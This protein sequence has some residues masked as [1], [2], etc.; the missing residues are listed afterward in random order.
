MTKEKRIA[1]VNLQTFFFARELARRLEGTGVTVNSLHP[2]VVDTELMRHMGL[3][4]SWVSGPFVRLLTWPFLKTAKSGAQTTLYA[5]LDPDLDKVTG[6][7][8][9][10]CQV[11][12]TS[13]LAKNDEL[14]KWLWAVSEKGTKTETVV[15]YIQ[16]LSLRGSLEYSF[17]SV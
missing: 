9:S 12:E 15:R 7:Y 3:F 6:L 4:T 14:A 13:D 8:F 11:R 16:L 1:K 17:P 2:G 10:D 5:A